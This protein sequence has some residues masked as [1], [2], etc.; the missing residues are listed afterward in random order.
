MPKKTGS[1]RRCD[2]TE[3]VSEMRPTL[4]LPCL[5]GGISDL[6]IERQILPPHIIAEG[7]P[8][9]ARLRRAR[10]SRGDR[11]KLTGRQNYLPLRPGVRRRTNVLGWDG[12]KSRSANPCQSD[13]GHPAQGC[14]PL[15]WV[16]PSPSSSREPH[17]GEHTLGGWRAG[18]PDFGLSAA[19]VR[20]ER[21]ILPPRVFGKIG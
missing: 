11:Q 3:P 12:V 21:Q 18:N 10:R 17:S 14:F 20:I 6:R 5:R 15:G 8:T 19:G 9:P 16:L 4:T 1:S 7:E 13:R 2:V